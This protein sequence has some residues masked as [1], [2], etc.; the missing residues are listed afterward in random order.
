VEREPDLAWE[1]MVEVCGYT[2][3]V[4][5]DMDDINGNPITVGGVTKTERGRINAALKELRAI[6]PASTNYAIA[7]DIR[8]RADVYRQKFPGMELTPQALVGNWSRI[9]PAEEARQPASAIDRPPLT[10]CETCDGLHLVL[11]SVTADGQEQY[12]PCPDCHP[13]PM[14]AGF[15]RY[16]GSRHNPPDAKRTREMMLRLLEADHAE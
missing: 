8:A 14:S 5:T 6:Y 3:E 16:D 10:R 15:W 11:V 4:P 12:A 13:S 2:H 9:D 1:A 7:F